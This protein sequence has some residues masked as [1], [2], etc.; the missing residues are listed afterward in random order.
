MTSERKE[1]CLVGDAILDNFYCLK[2]QTHDLR[3]ILI[4][5]G[6]HAHNYAVDETQ[7]KNI[8]KGQIPRKQYVE[9]RKYPYQLDSSGKVQP[10]QLLG[11][12][13]GSTV[14]MSIGGNDM[15]ASIP[16][17]IFGPDAFMSLVLSNKFKKR[18]KSVIQEILKNHRLILVVMYVPY[19]NTGPYAMMKGMADKIYG[20]WREF[21]YNLGRKFN[22]PVLDLSKTFDR[23]NRDHYG[24]TEVDPS[25]Y[26][27]TVIADGVDTII[28]DWKAGAWYNAD[29]SAGW[30]HRDFPKV[31]KIPKFLE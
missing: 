24:P 4:E 3:A 14:V 29:C 13:P 8:Q 21:I 12:H 19:V 28:K 2:D 10:L 30:K 27:V 6:Y 26:T 18:F 1:V 16:S 11:H 31:L 25:D 17:L 20:K 22:C 23:N 9:S 7:L 5:K 15:R